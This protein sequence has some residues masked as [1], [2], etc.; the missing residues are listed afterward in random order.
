MS[1]NYVLVFSLDI[2][3]SPYDQS[4][5][6]TTTNQYPLSPITRNSTYTTQS[7]SLTGIPLQIAPLTFTLTPLVPGLGLGAKLSINRS[8]AV[9]S[10]SKSSSS[11]R[12]N[13]VDSPMYNS[14]YAICIPTQE[15]VPRPKE[16]MY[17]ESCLPEGALGS[18]SQRDGL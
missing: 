4:H 11:N 8:T 7:I 18:L 9:R 12:R 13:N 3:Q 15:R 2:S 6:F 5:D 17:R 14:A 1:L 16:T 10:V